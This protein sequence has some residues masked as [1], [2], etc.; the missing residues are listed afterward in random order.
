MKDKPR[1]PYP[2]VDIIIERDGGVVLIRRRKPPPGWAIPGGFIEY[3]ESAENAAIREA[4]EETGLDVKLKEQFYTYSAP[5]RDPRFHTISI[6]FIAEGVGELRAG[7]D[8]GDAAVFYEDNL[9]EDIAFDHRK[10]L[11]HYFRY[12]RTGKRP[13]IGE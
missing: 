3:G 10:I 6:V 1:N 13:E 2:T 4:K 9:P 7:D 11:S 5:D 12:K 8:A